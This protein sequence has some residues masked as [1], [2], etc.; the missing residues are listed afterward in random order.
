[1]L[2][3][4]NLNFNTYGFLNATVK[5]IQSNPTPH[6]LSGRVRSR[7]QEEPEE[8]VKHCRGVRIKHETAQVVASVPTGY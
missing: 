1:M 3:H 2:F 7:P 5:F 8:A 6:R 4:R